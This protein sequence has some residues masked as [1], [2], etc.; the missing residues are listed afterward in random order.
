[1]NN[2]VF[3]P[4]SSGFPA[5]VKPVTDTHFL[6]FIMTRSLVHFKSETQQSAIFTYQVP[7]DNGMVVHK[8]VP[9]KRGITF[10]FYN[11]LQVLTQ[12]KRTKV[13]YSNWL[14]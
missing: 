7:K 6:S 2:D 13:R 1:M 4:F 5:Q 12:H 3:F 9:G 11:A 14:H 10:T 8:R